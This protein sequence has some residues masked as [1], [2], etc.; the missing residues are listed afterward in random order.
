[1]KK[2]TFLI[3]LISASISTI[4]AQTPQVPNG[5]FEN[6]TTTNWGDSAASWTNQFSLLTPI[7]LSKKSTSFHDGQFALEALSQAYTVF[8]STYNIPGI[9]TL[10]KIVPD[11]AHFSAKTEGGIPFN[12]KPAAL[13]GWY[14]YEQQGADS[15]IIYALLTRWNSISGTRDT[16]GSGAFMKNTAQLTYASFSATINYTNQSLT[17]DS[18]NIIILSSGLSATPGSKLTVDELVF[19]YTQ[20]IEDANNS[21]PSIYPNP[22]RGII[23]IS[24]QRIEKTEI[25]LYNVLGE[26]LLSTNTNNQ[27]S[28]IDVS[29]LPRG[30]YFLE[31]KSSHS[32]TTKRISLK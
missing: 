6:W 8:A 20:G 28:S 27:N 14:Q 12:G 26:K 15:A 32:K 16:V 23:N 10:G 31:L 3:L 30:I 13:N 17:P 22:A 25:S 2:I 4:L 1:M 24:L 11:I 7:I 18:L 19:Q 9:A 21:E 5:S 29:Y